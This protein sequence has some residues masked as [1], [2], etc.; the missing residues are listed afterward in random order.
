[1]K[2]FMTFISLILLFSLKGLAQDVKIGQVDREQIIRTLPAFTHAQEEM[3]R[4]RKILD[5]EINKTTLYY[6]QNPTCDSCVIKYQK[7]YEELMA[8]IPE[9][10]N[11][12]E[13]ELIAPVLQKVNQHI[14]SIAL[15]YGYLYVLDKGAAVESTTKDI[16]DLVL[17]RIALDR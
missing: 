4:F 7:Q 2:F 6:Q 12:K 8:K 1:M 5:D 3:A 17:K 11:N 16:T 10:L 9:L 13:K 14:E 15:E